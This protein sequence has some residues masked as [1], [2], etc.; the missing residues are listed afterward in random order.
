[1]NEVI[2]FSKMARSLSISLLFLALLLAV[3]CQVPAS[4]DSGAASVP[5]DIQENVA[6]QVPSAVAGGVP[7]PD[8]SEWTPER[9]GAASDEEL[10]KLAEEMAKAVIAMSRGI[11]APERNPSK[12]YR[13]VPNKKT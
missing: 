10:Q 13:D 11:A 6:P 7:R 4:T 3:L 5:A 8:F 1:V 2:I 12:V 9:V